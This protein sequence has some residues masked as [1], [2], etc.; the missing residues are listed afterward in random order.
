MPQPSP[1]PRAFPTF[2]V[3]TNEDA[4]GDAQRNDVIESPRA[5]AN[6]T[7][8]SAWINDCLTECYND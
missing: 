6:D 4:R 5:Q 2:I 1:N 8:A 7:D 3:A